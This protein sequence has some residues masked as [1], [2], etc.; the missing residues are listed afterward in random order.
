MYAVISKTNENEISSL[1]TVISEKSREFPA[2]IQAGY[3]IIFEGC[4]KSCEEFY[5]N[6]I[7][8][9]ASIED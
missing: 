1:P 3:E 4:R 7:L 9:F 2:F 6:L 8:E 5:E